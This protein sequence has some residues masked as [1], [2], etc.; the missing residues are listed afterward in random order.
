MIHMT[1]FILKSLSNKGALILWSEQ[2]GVLLFFLIHSIRGQAEASVQEKIWNK[3]KK[4]KK[5]KF[6]QNLT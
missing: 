6:K 5:Y 3:L 4:N 2:S 1:G